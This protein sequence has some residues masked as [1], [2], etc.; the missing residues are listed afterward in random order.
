MVMVRVRVSLQ[1]INVSLCNVPKSDLRK[2]VYV[3]VCVCVCVSKHAAS[4]ALLNS[5]RQIHSTALT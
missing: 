3:C 2:N 5:V 4:E 1:E